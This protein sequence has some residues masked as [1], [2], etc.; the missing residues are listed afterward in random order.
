MAR[1][2]SQSEIEHQLGL[3]PRSLST[4]LKLR[5]RLKETSVC[6]DL[7]TIPVEVSKRE[8]LFLESNPSWRLWPF[9]YRPEAHYTN[10]LALVG[11]RYVAFGPRALGLN[12]LDWREEAN[13]SAKLDAKT[14]LESIEKFAAKKHSTKTSTSAP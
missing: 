8:S 14:T 2:Q 1:G 11:S 12:L 10:R 6:I 3:K 13:Q 7:I 9:G 4:K 5:S